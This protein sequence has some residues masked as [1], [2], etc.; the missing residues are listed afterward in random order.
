MPDGCG[1][2]AHRSHLDNG[3]SA[4]PIHRRSRSSGAAGSTPSGPSAA[5]NSK[6]DAAR[7]GHATPRYLTQVTASPTESLPIQRAD[8]PSEGA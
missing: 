5:A 2:G 8:A 7:P 4:M 3:D 6:S 1:A